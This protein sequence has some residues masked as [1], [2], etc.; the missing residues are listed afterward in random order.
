MWASA[1]WTKSESYF[2]NFRR[3][4]V[5]LR[6]LKESQIFLII[7]NLDFHMH[8]ISRVSIST[9]IFNRGELNEGSARSRTCK[10]TA[11]TR[12]RCMREKKK[13]V[14]TDLRR[15]LQAGGQSADGEV[16]G[17]GGARPADG[18]H[19]HH[20]QEQQQGGHD[21][22]HED[23][24]P[25][26]QFAFFLQVVFGAVQGVL[27]G[28]AF[29]AGVRVHGHAVLGEL[30]LAVAVVQH[31]THLGAAVQLVRLRQC[32]FCV[33]LFILLSA[34]SAVL[35]RQRGTTGTSDA[36]VSPAGCVHAVVRV[37]RARVAPPKT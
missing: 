29:A 12:K 22:Q 4:G 37:V 19:Q 17:V 28:D 16:L 8:G 26:V 15:G 24:L 27:L 36:A 5:L 33:R 20:D 21:G 2:R 9:Y 6:K 31:R 3:L 1:T 30:W 7:P 14:G 11:R 23:Q 34:F 13:H 32:H 35:G 10:F 18:Q 25:P